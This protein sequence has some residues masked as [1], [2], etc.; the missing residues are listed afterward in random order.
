MWIA[1]FT[2]NILGPCPSIRFYGVLPDVPEKKNYRRLLKGGV[3]KQEAT[4]TPVA[5]II[6]QQIDGTMAPRQ[7]KLWQFHSTIE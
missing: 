3:F 2:E 6:S 5:L 4:T 1:T 7:T